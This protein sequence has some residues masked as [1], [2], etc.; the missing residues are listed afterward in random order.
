MGVRKTESRIPGGFSLE[1]ANKLGFAKQYESNNKYILVSYFGEVL[2]Q[3]KQSP[4]YY[5]SSNTYVV[6]VDE[7][8]TNQSELRYEWNFEFLVQDQTKTIIYTDSTDYG[9]FNLNIDEIFSLLGQVIQE[10]RVTLTIKESAPEIVISMEH[11][12]EELNGRIEDLFM[13]KP[14]IYSA[15]GGNNKITRFLGND[16][17]PYF[18]EYTDSYTNKKMT[19]PPNLVAAV[20]Y[21]QQLNTSL[22]TQ[23]NYRETWEAYINKGIAGSEIAKTPLGVANINPSLLVMFLKTFDMNE[24]RENS[25][26]LLAKVNWD[27]VKDHDSYLETVSKNF[28]PGNTTTEENRIDI[29]NLLRFPRSAIFTCAA[30]L[31]A[32]QKNVPNDDS[33]DR[34]EWPSLA[35]AELMENKNAIQTIVSE[36]DVGPTL[37]LKSFTKISKQTYSTMFSKYIETIIAKDYIEY[38]IVKIKVLD[39]RSG[40]PLKNKK[41]K[42]LFVHD[43]KYDINSSNIAIIGGE[44]HYDKETITENNSVKAAQIALLRLGYAPAGSNSGWCDGVWGD[45]TKDAYNA[46]WQNRVLDESLQWT[47]NKKVPDFYYLSRIVDEYNS[48]AY[49]NDKGIVEIKIP[50]KFLDNREVF[51]DIGFWEFPIVI[52][53]IPIPQSSSSGCIMRSQSA[54]NPTEFKVSWVGSQTSE[55]NDY[56]PND[57]DDKH[58]GWSVTDKDVTNS[59]FLKVW[60]RITVKDNT[61]IFE[62]WNKDLF[63]PYYEKTGDHFVLFGME[64]CQPVWYPIPKK[65]THWIARSRNNPDLLHETIPVSKRTLPAI[66]TRWESGS[67]KSLGR[68][69]D[70][71][72]FVPYPT[73]LKDANGNYNAPRFK[74]SVPK[75]HDG[76]DYVAVEGET[77]AFA[78]H[79]GVS[80]DVRSKYISGTL[81]SGYGNNILIK[82]L[83]KSNKY[84]YIRMAHFYS[85]KEF[86]DV[87]KHKQ[88]DNIMAGQL[89]GR[90][91]RTFN[92]TTNGTITLFPKYAP[93]HMHI[94]MCNAPGVGSNT[95]QN[96]LK[97]PKNIIPAV[98]N[99]NR[100][101]YLDNDSYRLFPCDCGESEQASQCAIKANANE[102]KYISSNCWASRNLHCPYLAGIFLYRAQLIYL[103]EDPSNTTDPKYLEPSMKSTSWDTNGDDGKAIRRFREKHQVRI[104]GSNPIPASTHSFWESEPG[105]PATINT[106]NAIAPYPRTDTSREDQ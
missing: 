19:T 10:I 42:Q 31:K 16:I 14:D 98:D 85:N 30:F 8:S 21:L 67:S 12:V 36:Y 62:G 4:N 79:G 101:L 73:Q 55:W 71:G 90:A 41:V 29:F 6:F 91:G 102:T 44:F 77:P 61:D 66:A 56:F 24:N 65:A 47:D 45:S 25:D 50:K 104:F 89:L 72:T 37:N 46:Y 84:R 94:E 43:T 2:H 106:L 93:T 35:N 95:H 86:E 17:Q 82:F 53:K 97:Y 51:I 87:F 103:A 7:D 83:N 38:H 81:S 26:G 11:T 13:P 48:H 60:Q 32:L 54:E 96:R 52:E 99:P 3:S 68:G 78:P 34:S 70:Y 1:N 5:L 27:G 33:T 23:N 75:A 69:R 100:E 63:S 76:I 49:T 92:L 80:W 88:D 28:V 57:N 105:D 40:K 39:I 15:I 9:V 58:F 18:K 22:E 74:G 59:S 20:I 64:W